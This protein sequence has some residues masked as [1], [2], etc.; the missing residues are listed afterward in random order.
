MVRIV[1]FPIDIILLDIRLTKFEPENNTTLKTVK[2][3]QE[4]GQ[5]RPVESI[6][7]SE[8]TPS[9]ER[10]SVIVRQLT[11]SNLNFFL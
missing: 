11:V 2:S 6:S 8:V 5:N 10:K 4:M 1:A 9:V 7:V 3:R